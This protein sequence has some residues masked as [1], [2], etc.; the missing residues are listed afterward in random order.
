MSCSFLL[1]GYAPYANRGCEAIVR[2]TTTILRQEFGDCRLFSSYL[3]ESAIN[4]DAS[5]ETDPTII[6][7]PRAPVRLRRFGLLWWQWRLARLFT[8]RAKDIV[9]H[10]HLRRA[11]H[12]ARGCDA[13]LMVGG[14]NYTLDYGYPQTAF[15]HLR[16]AREMGKPTILWG[17]SIGPFSR[18]PEYEDWAAGELS[19]ASLVLVRETVTLDYLKSIGVEDNVRLVADPAFRLEPRPPARLSALVNRALSAGCIGVNLS[20][21]IARYCDASVDWFARCTLTLTKLLDAFKEPILLI[22]HVT[23]DCGDANGDDHLF[24]RKLVNTIGADEERLVLLEPS[25]QASE[26]KWVISRVRL[27]AGARTHSTIAAI[28]SAVPTLG[29]GYS[30]KARGISRDVYG[31]DRWLISGTEFD[32]DRFSALLLSMSKEEMSI[33]HHLQQVVPALQTRATEAAAYLREVMERDDH[34]RL[35][36]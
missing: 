29:I 17:A 26:T 23:S 33:R 4:K 20:P 6:H 32:P 19:K 25:L 9:V 2:G 10:G 34:K 7:L 31:H 28:S 1:V 11:L 5:R 13:V 22:P 12:T 14:D 27:F 30:A 15:E 21:L 18:D 8:N 35:V 36:G 16:M 24:M 3:D